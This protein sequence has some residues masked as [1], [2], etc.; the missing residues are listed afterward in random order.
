MRA[1][2]RG[3][4]SGQF[5]GLLNPVGD[6][7]LQSGGL[8][9]RAHD[10][11]GARPTHASRYPAAQ[12]LFERALAVQQANMGPDNRQLIQTLIPYADLLR[13][14][15]RDSDAAAIDARIAA[16]RKLTQPQP[17]N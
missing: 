14:M 5:Q 17:Q 13:H 8:R 9:R 1:K 10:E 3:S 11:V 7:S 12:Q 6:F 2:V 4:S 15:H 16:L